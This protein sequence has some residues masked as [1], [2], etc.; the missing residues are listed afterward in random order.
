MGEYLYVYMYICMYIL[1]YEYTHH[2]INV[3]YL[4]CVGLI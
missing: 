1:M 4:K 3:M 2:I